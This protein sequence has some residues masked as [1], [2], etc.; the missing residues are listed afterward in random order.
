[1]G[2][3][4]WGPRESDTTE[5]LSTWRLIGLCLLGTAFSKS[6]VSLGSL[7]TF[8]L[9]AWTLSLAVRSLLTHAFLAISL[10]GDSVFH[11]LNFAGEYSGRRSTLVYRSFITNYMIDIIS[12]FSDGETEANRGGLH[13]IR[14]RSPLLNEDSNL[15]FWPQDQPY[16][17]LSIIP[18]DHWSLCQ[19]IWWQEPNDCK[20][21]H[22]Y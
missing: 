14:Q 19:D 12:I 8:M 11:L 21:Q 5:Q 4:P 2:Y 1:M 6:W 22:I 20:N 15:V 10:S 16:L 3:S 17:H 13:R 7:C 9:P 18:I